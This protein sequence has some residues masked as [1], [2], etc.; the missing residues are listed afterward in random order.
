MPLTQG[1]RLGPYEVLAP[2]GAGGM[3]EVYRARDTRLGREVAVKVLPAHLTESAEL[4]TRFE[5]EARTVSSLNHPNICT[6][7]DVGRENGTDYLVME[8]VEGESLADRLTRGALPLAEIV[9]LGAQ[10]A[11]AL[12]RAHRAGILHRDLKP[13]NV[14]LAKAGAKLMDFGL[15]RPAAPGGADPGLTSAQPLTAHGTIVGTYQY[16]APELLEGRE[17]DV[18]SD[19]WALGCVLY[20]MATGRP[21]Y[22]GSSP[23]SLISAI[24]RE[25]PRA[26]AE[27]APMAPAS[28]ES[29]VR[30]CLAKDPE[31]R[32]QSAHDVALALRGPQGSG[33]AAVPE[34]QEPSYRQLTFGRGCIIGAKFAPDGRTVVYDAAWEGGDHRIYLTRTDSPETT[35][36]PLP[37]AVL[38]AVSSRSDLAI[39]LDRHFLGSWWLATGMLAQAP[40]FGGSPR[41]VAPDVY[42]AAFL[43]GSDAVAVTRRVGHENVVEFPIG[44]P[45]FRSPWWIISLAVSPDGAHIAFVD[46]ATL[47]HGALLRVFDRQGKEVIT[48]PFHFWNGGI[49]WRPDGKAVLSIDSKSA[50]G[51][52]LRETDLSGQSRHRTRFLGGY[53]TLHDIAPSGDVLLS[54]QTHTY[55]ITS[56][57][58]GQPD[59]NLGQFDFPIGKSLSE[60]GRTLLY[61]EQ[62]LAN[63]GELYTY[64]RA[65]DGSPPV[66]LG[67]GYARDLSPDGKWAINIHKSKVRL[68]PRG[69]GIPRKLDLGPIGSTHLINWHPDGQRLVVMGSEKGRPMRL[70]VLPIAGG[71]PRAITPEGVSY[72]SGAIVKMVSNDGTRVAA[73]TPDNV[74]KIHAIEDGAEVGSWQL[75]DGEEPVRWCAGDGALFVWRRGDVPVRVTRFDLTTGER[76]FWREYP[77]GN[78]VGVVC[79]RS[80]LMTAD[81]ET[82][83]HT[84]SH[85]ISELFVARGLL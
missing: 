84:Y 1:T 77:P 4:R 70:Y 85:M 63:E 12:D 21:A 64:V 17:A 66:R 42:E 72:S 7:H 62:G 22:G 29:I 69:A 14:M 23:A 67:P 56:T 38:H 41:E 65:T 37:P 48:V 40:L 32:W 61:D 3:G 81:G 54:R 76:T 75:E 71:A 11:D 26:M 15:S 68:L 80:L 59:A 9:R 31:Q 27:L 33:P 30:G 45:V 25:E 78:R 34:A 8:L 43:P 53:V 16:M 49:A 2:L 28:L 13:G 52:R 35:M 58:P 47:L 10:I 50:D 60:D 44:N 18:R 46:M 73:L 6:L 24:L 51:A 36:L 39:S 82:C 5:R 20:E 74:L 19:L 55:T 83:V 57:R 79:S